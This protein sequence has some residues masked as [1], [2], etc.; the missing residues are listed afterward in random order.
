MIKTWFI[1]D[2]H[3]GHANILKFEPYYRPFDTIEEHDQELIKRWNSVVRPQDHVYHLGD[4][5]FGQQNLYK[6]GV[7][8]GDKRLIMGNHDCYKTESYMQYFTKL[9]GCLQWNAFCILSHI[10]VHED[11]L[12]GRY[13]YNI[14]GHKHSKLVLDKD[15]NPD[16]RYINVSV[17]Q[18]NL[19][20]ISW[21]EL[22][23]R[24]INE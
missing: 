4:A 7:L 11:Q 6:L 15:G 24:Y 18:Q 9:Y 13:R 3:I 2:T 5:V 19:T 14:H 16:K 21:E 12:N 10:P 23:E 17:E 1:S 8:N 20:P 22:K